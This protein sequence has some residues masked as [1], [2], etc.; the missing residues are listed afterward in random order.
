MVVMVFLNG[1]CP[2]LIHIVACKFHHTFFLR[3]GL[4]ACSA[5]SDDHC[6]VIIFICLFACL[7]RLQAGRK[8]SIRTL[9]L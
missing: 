6:F 2:V 1:Q 9:L 3:A 5:N 7:E 4:G 8:V